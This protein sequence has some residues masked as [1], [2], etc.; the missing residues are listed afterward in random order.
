M[1]HDYDK[2]QVNG[3]SLSVNQDKCCCHPSSKDIDYY[4]GEDKDMEY[5]RAYIKFQ[6]YENV[7]DAKQALCRGTAFQDLDMPCW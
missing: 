6:R 2:Y 7:Y 3:N 4:R 1:Y 5:A